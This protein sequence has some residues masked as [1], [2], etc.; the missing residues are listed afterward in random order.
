MNYPS[1]KSSPNPYIDPINNHTSF[2]SENFEFSRYKDESENLLSNES[3]KLINFSINKF[4]SQLRIESNKPTNFSSNNEGEC[5]E[6]DIPNDFLNKNNIFEIR[7]LENDFNK[8]IFN[9]NN[10]YN[11][12]RL[13]QNFIQEEK[14]ESKIHLKKK[15]NN[16]TTKFK[17]DNLIRKVKHILLNNLLNFIN[18]KIS[19]LSEHETMFGK[20]KNIGQKERSEGN[21]EYN[22]QFLNK[23]LFEIFSSKITGRITNFLSD[24]NGKIIENL[25]KEKDDNKRKYF[26]DL[27]NLTFT[28][29]LNHFN[30]TFYYK[31]LDGMKRM[32]DEVKKESKGDEEYKIHLNHYF[33]HFEEIINNKKGKKNKDNKK[34]I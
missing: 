14:K 12:L 21:I 11:Y 3:Y 33:L 24:Y 30:G 19:E 32:V 13:P 18:D 9:D 17:S 6:E 22:K 5:L 26:N 27:F 28:Q 34:S 15:R 20:L 25:L 7:N 31:E 23:T 1:P 4:D 29:S 2:Y 8:E 10:N 16:N